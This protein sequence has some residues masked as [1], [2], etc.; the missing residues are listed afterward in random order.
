MGAG[1]DDH[2]DARVSDP[3]ELRQ[4]SLDRT[5]WLRI[6]V[7]QVAA[8]EHHVHATFEAHVHGPRERGQLALALLG[9]RLAQVGMTS[10]QVDVREMEQQRHV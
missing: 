8:D 9:R 6:G 2:A 7:E 10:S 4:R 1:D 3:L 5:A